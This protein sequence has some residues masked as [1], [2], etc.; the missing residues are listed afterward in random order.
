[1][2]R[3]PCSLLVLPVLCGLLASCTKEIPVELDTYEERISIE[4]LLQPGTTPRVYV[5]RTVPFFS[6]D[7]T[8]SQL[9]VA[10]ADVVISSSNGAEL[11]RADSIYSRFYCR[12]E[13]FYTG[14]S[15]IMEDVEYSLN[16]TV[17]GE[18]Y[19]ATTVTNV[20]A[21]RIDSVSY[22]A[23]FTDIYGGHEGVLVDFVDLP[24][25]PNQYRFLMTRPLN[26]EHQTVDDR[27]WSSPCMADGETFDVDE[28]GR[29]V[30]F[31]TNFDG[32]PV[33]LVAEPAYTNKKGDLGIVY[34]QSLSRDVA[35]YYDAL[36]RQREANINPFIEPVFLDSKIDGAIGVFGAVNRSEPYYFEFPEDSE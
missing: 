15:V 25:Q 21:A 30:Y 18:T 13:P 9:F 5:N 22:T 4:G 1:M 19:S 31:D 20:P 32:A 8:P 34:I 16:V 36:D 24:G 11:L 28:I 10:G 14:N 3:L 26:N 2:C 7:V 12:F 27:E 6:T 17:G 29:V 35:E 33:R 23:D